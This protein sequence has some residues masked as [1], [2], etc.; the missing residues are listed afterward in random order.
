[1]PDDALMRAAESGQLTTKAQVADQA[2]RM[3]QDK[4]VAAIL[5][6]F[7]RQWLELDKLD[8]L[9]KEAAVVPGF[10]SDIGPLMKTEAQTFVDAVLSSAKPDLGSL[11]Q[12]PFSFMNAKLAGFYGVKGPTAAAFERVELDP[13]QRAGILTL[14]GLLSIQAHPDQ[15]SPVKRGLF[16]RRQ[17]LCDS[18]PPP[19]PNVVVQLP[20]ADPSLSTRERFGQHSSDPYCKACHQLMDPIGLGF[21]SYDAAGRYRSTE[22]GKAI[23]SSGQLID[24]VDI[25]GTFVGAVDLAK[26]LAGSSQVSD[27]TVTEWFRY[28]YGRDEVDGQDACNTAQLR[29]TFAKSG[30]NVRELMFALTQTDAF[31]YRSVPEGESP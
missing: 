7:H 21:E 26:R 27:C 30:Q 29:D 17:L 28:A 16:V 13:Q 22:N 20:K 23:D 8:S 3:L 10:T 2:R 31:F 1:M 14:G 19:P 15:T 9:E 25:D 4:R 12:S 11:L 6:D 24:T 18:P 5:A